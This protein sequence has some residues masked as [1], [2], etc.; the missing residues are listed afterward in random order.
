[1][2]IDVLKSRVSDY[3]RK[4]IEKA[5]HGKKRLTKSTLAYYI[6]MGSPHNIYRTEYSDFKREEYVKEFNQ[7]WNANL[8]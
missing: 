4:E 5:E 7:V 8:K 6:G 3:G 1:M 2:T